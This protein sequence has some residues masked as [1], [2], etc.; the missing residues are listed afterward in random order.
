MKSC[1]NG[2][3]FGNL[4]PQE[5]VF[6]FYCVCLIF[7]TVLYALIVLFF[8]WT[9]PV[10]GVFALFTFLHLVI[11]MMMPTGGLRHVWWSRTFQAFIALV[12][13]MACFVIPNRVGTY[14][15]LPRMLSGIALFAS[16]AGGFLQSL[17]VKFC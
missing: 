14:E 12:V 17:F 1:P 10:L 4:S 16:I 7:R 5:R 9:R 2:N 11:R 15:G 6:L 8:P 3:L 13:L